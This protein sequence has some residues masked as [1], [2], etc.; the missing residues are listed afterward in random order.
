MSELAVQVEDLAVQMVDQGTKLLQED[1]ER[2]LVEVEL[3]EA[4]LN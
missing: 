1:Q 4:A 2:A 3:L